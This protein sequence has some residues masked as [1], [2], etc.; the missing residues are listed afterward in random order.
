MLL[1][2]SFRCP[3]RVPGAFEEDG[4][5]VFLRNIN[6]IRPAPHP[7]EN[8]RYEHETGRK[9]KGK[10]ETSLLPKARHPPEKGHRN[11]GDHAADVDGGVEHGKV[12]GEGLG[13]LREFELV[14]SKGDHTGLDPASADGYQEDANVRDLD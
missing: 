1:L 6:L 5:D 11:G 14:G 4:D 7:E 13:L 9:T 2:S 10:R 8:E 3:E 12:G